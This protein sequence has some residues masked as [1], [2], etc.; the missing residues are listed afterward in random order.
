M[1]EQ[2][3]IC[4][5]KIVKASDKFL[6]ESKQAVF[7]AGEE[8]DLLRFHINKSLKYVCRVCVDLLKKR[9]KARIKLSNID[10]SIHD[11]FVNGRDEKTVVKEKEKSIASQPTII[12]DISTSDEAEKQGL[13]VPEDFL[14]SSEICT[15]R[16]SACVG[17]IQVEKQQKD[18]LDDECIGPL[19]AG[20]FCS[21]TPRSKTITNFEREQQSRE[22]ELLAESILKGDVANSDVQPPANTNIKVLKSVGTQ[23]LGSRSLFGK[24][25]VERKGGTTVRIRVEWPSVT[26]E[27]ELGKDLEQLGK[28]LCRGTYKEIAAAAWKHESIR[29]NLVHLFLRKIYLECSNICSQK[30]NSMLR[31]TSKEEMKSFEFGALEE[32]LKIVTPLFWSVLKTAAFCSNREKDDG[33]EA[34]FSPAVCMAASICLKNRCAAMTAM[35]LLVTIILQHSGMMVSIDINDYL[36]IFSYF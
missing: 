8:I 30:K 13:I 25:T 3:V 17:L 19:G 5:S 29:S 2:C 16:P 11:R 34:A 9:R 7:K 24:S 32:E 27:R 4:S 18:W 31:K 21:S 36:S 22:E 10:S 28:T 33:S 35:Q 15:A 20:I 14:P 12:A 6:V 26:R 23:T 1:E